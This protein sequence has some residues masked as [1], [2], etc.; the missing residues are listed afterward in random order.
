MKT[1]LFSYR[2]QDAEWSFEVQADDERDARVRVYKMGMARFDGALIVK[3][4]T[5]VGLVMRPI[6]WLR[7]KLKEV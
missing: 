2:H 1:Y 5:Y 3:V 6:V 7:N 4:P